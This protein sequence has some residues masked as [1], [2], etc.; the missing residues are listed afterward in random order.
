R[1]ESREVYWPY[2]ADAP[3]ADRPSGDRR[4]QDAV[5][6]MARGVNQSFDARI[7]AEYR[8]VVRRARTQ[9]G[10]GVD[11]G[12]D[13]DAGHNLNGVFDDRSHAGGRH[14]LVVADAFGSRSG[15]QISAEPGNQVS[16]S[17][18]DHVARGRRGHFNRRH[19]PARRLD[20]KPLRFIATKQARPTSRRD[21]DRAG[22]N[23]APRRHY[24]DDPPSPR[25]ALGQYLSRFGVSQEL[26][27]GVPRRAMQRGHQTAV[28]NLMVAGEFQGET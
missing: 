25:D 9:P 4:K 2:F 20:F 15:D 7:G 8:Q 22:M 11:D 6:I 14:S 3:F 27:A 17:R 10:P 21:H 18:I 23:F 24:P 28:V 1:A 5:A 16:A 19:L 26:D 13:G 12:L